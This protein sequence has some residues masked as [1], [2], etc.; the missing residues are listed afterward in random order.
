[1]K[2]SI[3]IL[4]ILLF[5]IDAFSQDEKDWQRLRTDDGEMAVK[6]PAGCYSNFYDPNGITIYDPDKREHYLLT[7]M[8]LI[9]CFH[10]RT[11]MTL[12]IYETEQS[13]EAAKVLQKNLK[14]DGEELNIGE[15]F[16]SV[17]KTGKTDKYSSKQRIIAGK[18]HVYIFTTAARGEPL[19]TM[20][21]FLD[22]ISF[23]ADPGL[24]TEK[25]SVLISSLENTLPEVVTPTEADEKKTADPESGKV[26]EMLTPVVRISIPA[27]FYTEAARQKR[28]IGRVVLR[29]TLGADGR[30]SQLQVV[31]GLPFGL[32]REAI[33]AALRIKFL[34]AELDGAPRSTTQLIEYSF[35]RS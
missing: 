9:S 6:F 4:L 7:Q 19:D 12:E 26:L 21:I 5:A 31:R 18:K 27:A 33:I 17:E 35:G 2:K 8:R 23:T 1:M 10:D 22:S 13:R 32:L 15:N 24:V 3:F 29:L 25:N 28:T 34:P 11:L 16:Y 20:Q 30:I 14:I